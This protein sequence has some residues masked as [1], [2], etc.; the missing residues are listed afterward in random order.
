MHKKELIRKLTTWVN[1]PVHI[2]EGWKGQRPFVLYLIDYLKELIIPCDE[3]YD[4]Y[5]LE[6]YL[7]QLLVDAF[8]HLRTSSDPLVTKHRTEYER[9]VG[10]PVPNIT[11]LGESNILDQGSAVHTTLQF[12]FRDVIGESWIEHEI[13]AYCNAQKIVLQQTFDKFLRLVFRNG[14]ALIIDSCKSAG[15]K[16]V[17][18]ATELRT[19]CTAGRIM[20]TF[21]KKN[22]NDEQEEYSV[23]FVAEDGDP[24]AY[25]AGIQS[26]HANLKIGM[27]LIEDVIT[28]WPTN[29]DKQAK[30]HRASK[31]FFG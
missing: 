4:F 11:E 31:V 15:M 16:G 14:L 22:G 23:S 8:E 2:R 3:K 5:T 29:A 6:P 24:L 30:S 27:E 10:H 1:D 18:G 25:S 7:P 28:N 17:F 26:V 21:A 19:F 9:E 13:G 12:V 20:F